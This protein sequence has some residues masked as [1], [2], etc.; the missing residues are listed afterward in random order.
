[1]VAIVVSVAGG[2]NAATVLTVQNLTFTQYTG[3]A[4]KNEMTTVQPTDWYYAPAGSSPLVFVLWYQSHD[5][6]SVVRFQRLRRV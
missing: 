1:M 6:R 5:E 4:P 3:S 2:A